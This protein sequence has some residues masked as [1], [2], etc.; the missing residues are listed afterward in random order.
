MANKK[1]PKDPDPRRAEA[2][3]IHNKSKRVGMPSVREF[4]RR[5]FGR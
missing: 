3:G 5:L 1:P 2:G 4:F